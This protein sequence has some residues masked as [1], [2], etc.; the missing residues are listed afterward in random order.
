VYTSTIA[1]V[2]V[3]HERSACSCGATYLCV[4]QAASCVSIKQQQQLAQHQQQQF[5]YQL[6]HQTYNTKVA[7]HVIH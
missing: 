3:Q 1:A 4:I 2:R 5:L 7:L 6:R